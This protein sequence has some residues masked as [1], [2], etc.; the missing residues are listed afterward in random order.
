MNTCFGR[1]LWYF[2]RWLRTSTLEHQLKLS[3]AKYFAHCFSD[4]I[5]Y[6][7][8]LL[9]PKIFQHTRFWAIWEFLEFFGI[10]TAIWAKDKENRKN[11]MLQLKNYIRFIRLK[12]HF[13][14]KTTVTQRGLSFQ[15][16]DF[17]R[18][19]LRLHNVCKLLFLR[20]Y[21]YFLNPTD[22]IVKICRLTFPAVWV[23]QQFRIQYSSFFLL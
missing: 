17:F 1:Q 18:S 14:Y 19:P 10:K 20:I 22:D 9:C 15:V 3:Q 7:R 23:N 21:D 11:I 5:S 2:L 8:P 4:L 16:L 12:V 13:R 6:R